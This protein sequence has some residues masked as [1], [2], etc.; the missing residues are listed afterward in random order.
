MR[1]LRWP[2]P[3]LTPFLGRPE[4]DAADNVWR[5]TVPVLALALALAFAGL[6]FVMPFLPLYLQE[7]GVRDPSDVRVWSG[8]MAGAGSLGFAVSAP[9]WGVVADRV[10]RKPMVLRAMGLGG[11][12]AIAA[13]FVA[14]PTQLIV[15][16]ILHGFVIGPATA[17]FALASSVMPRA[18][19]LRAMGLMQV[20][21][22][23][24]QSLGP[25]A[26][27]LSADFFG[28]RPTLVLG[29]AIQ[30]GGAALVLAFVRENFTRRGAARTLADLPGAMPA[31]PLRRV[32]MS[33]TFTAIMGAQVALMFSQNAAGA[34]M[35]LYVQ[36]LGEP[37]RASSYTGFI[38]G[39]FSVCAGAAALSAGRVVDRF[40][41]KPTLIA[42]IT[43]MALLFIPQAFAPNV[44]VL[45]G[46]R[47][48]QGAF[49]GF[50]SPSIQ[51][52]I[53]FVT[54]QERRGTVYGI[55][56]AATGSGATVGPLVT[57]AVAAWVG[58]PSVF[59]V[60]AGIALIG[61]L[62]VAL[63]LD[64]AAVAAASSAPRPR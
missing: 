30:I 11:V 26:G 7:L 17:S 59:V 25:F 57:G 21:M 42:A 63:R 24:G 36:E 14:D 41:L 44:W 18:N 12:A 58:L 9:L 22:L 37:A 54:P 31:L 60:L 32:V 53:G 43:G 29:G 39:A 56:G 40:T 19:L 51:T 6:G 46:S 50:I 23:V 3:S 10:G 35:P 45:L 15:L 28:I 38:Q 64:R 4:P 47:A 20:S 48:A 1:R 52:V 27:G 61:A 33:A 49:A 16:R 62:W 34:V 5:T 13:A 8:V 2:R 55:M